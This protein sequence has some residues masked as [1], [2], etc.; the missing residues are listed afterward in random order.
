MFQFSK[1]L[2]CISDGYA[3]YEVHSPSGSFILHISQQQILCQAAKEV[4]HICPLQCSSIQVCYLISTFI[5]TINKIP[6]RS[7][8][9]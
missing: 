1:I 5:Y 3:S 2:Y 6:R 7:N 8:Q 9:Q 4:S